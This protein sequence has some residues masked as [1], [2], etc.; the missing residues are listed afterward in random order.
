MV[1]VFIPIAVRSITSALVL[2][3]GG[4]HREISLLPVGSF[5]LMT[6][7][8]RREFIP[9]LLA[10]VTPLTSWS[11]GGGERMGIIAGFSFVT[12]R[13]TT[14]RDRSS[15]GMLVFWTLRS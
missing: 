13:C 8:A 7:K 4:T 12:I 3:S 15:A 11:C 6:A 2:K 9:I 5:I 1:N 10:L 14:T